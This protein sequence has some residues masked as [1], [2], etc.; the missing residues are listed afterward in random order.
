MVSD[1]PVPPRL[2]IV[3]PRAILHLEYAACTVAVGFDVEQADNT[4]QGMAKATLLAPDIVLTD[5]SAETGGAGV[6]FCRRLKAR[7]ATSRIPVLGLIG[8]GDPLHATAAAVAG[9]TVLA[10]PC[11][12][13]RLLV[14]IVRVLGVWPPGPAAVA[15][16]TTVDQLTL[17]LGRVLRVNAQI[18]E[19]NDCLSSAAH[20]W[21]TWYERTLK[22]ANQASVDGR[23]SDR[24]LRQRGQETRRDG[25]EA[26]A[27]AP[28]SRGRL[29]DR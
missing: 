11:S 19:R 1:E 10:K 3:D 13:E 20:L 21:A 16:S 9:C 8:A 26:R 22:R 18:M 12:P 6:E 23:H 29:T 27:T 24:S 2:L 14:E 15:G 17:M 5:C 25:C 4:E 28:R 7:V